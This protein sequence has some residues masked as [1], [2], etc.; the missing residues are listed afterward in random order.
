MSNHLNKIAVSILGLVVSASALAVTPN[1]FEREGY[2]P[3][4]GQVKN[5]NGYLM[6]R[7]TVND[8][9]SLNFCSPEKAKVIAKM[10]DR[11]KTFGKNTVL[12]R[13]WDGKLQNWNYVALNKTTNRI[14]FLPMAISSSVEPYKNIKLTYG[15][16]K[17]RICTTGSNIELGGDMYV[18]SFSAHDAGVGNHFCYIYNDKTGF[19]EAKSLNIKTGKP[20]AVESD[21]VL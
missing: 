16:N 12:M 3:S 1:P 11:K 9:S 6:D 21:F 4:Y 15:K 2:E 18:K 5:V 10:T 14:F 8:Y 7:C 20:A 13:F 19:S 17:D